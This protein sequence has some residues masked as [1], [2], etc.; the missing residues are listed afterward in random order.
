MPGDEGFPRYFEMPEGDPCPK[1]STKIQLWEMMVDGVRNNFMLTGAFM[2]IGAITTF[3]GFELESGAVKKLVFKELGIPENARVLA[4]NYTAQGRGCFPVELH[5]NT[6]YRGL[7]RESVQV[8][9]RPYDPGF[10]KT[11]IACAI[12]WLL[13]PDEDDGWS[14]LLDAFRAYA[15]GDWR[16][17]IIPANIAAEA[18]ISK[19]AHDAIAV[20]EVANEEKIEEFLRDATYSHQ[21]NVLLPLI[22]KFQRIARL[23]DEVRGRLNRLR[24]LRNKVAHTGALPSP[25]TKN[26]VAELVVAATFGFH[27]GRFFRRNLTPDS[28]SGIDVACAR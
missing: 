16:G 20:A 6:P 13:A 15:D 18:A 21:L 19:G 7:P 17:A 2:A 22:A 9:G 27:Y 8:Y 28:P 11:E 5:G 12:T 1:C 10:P 26:E 23:P 4:I 24:N 25:L 14:H 3:F